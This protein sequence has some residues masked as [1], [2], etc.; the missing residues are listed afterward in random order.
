[1]KRDSKGRF[2]TKGIVI[3][4]PSISFGNKLPDNFILFASMDI[5]RSKTRYL[6]K[7][8]SISQISIL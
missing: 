8:I 2:T 1:M 7:S 4:F 6:F 3:P 5:C